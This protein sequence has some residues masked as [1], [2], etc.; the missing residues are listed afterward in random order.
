MA[1]KVNVILP[2]QA[3]RWADAI[4]DW[5]WTWLIVRLALTSLFLLSVLIELGDFPAAVAVQAHFGLRPA[6]L[7]AGVVI[8]V[9]LVGSLILL[10]GRYVWLGAGM[11]GGLT[12]GTEIVAHRFWELSGAA[13]SAA[14]YE[15]FEHLGLIAG[16]VLVTAMARARHQ[17]AGC[18]RAHTS[19]GGGPVGPAPKGHPRLERNTDE[20][21]PGIGG[22]RRGG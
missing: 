10:S 6:A 13:E 1:V 22:G 11:L 15:F 17:A 21:G 16:L 2:E 18:A 3:P 7:W 12:G 9:Q 5:R 4:L 8:V 14:R 19:E 20:A